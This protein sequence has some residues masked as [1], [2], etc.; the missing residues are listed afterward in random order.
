MSS[1]YFFVKK[2]D[3]IVTTKDSPVSVAVAILNFTH[4]ALQVKV[5]NELFL[6]LLIL[7]NI[8]I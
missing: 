3:K 1:F 6:M 2:D 7:K 8:Q 4:D 5:H